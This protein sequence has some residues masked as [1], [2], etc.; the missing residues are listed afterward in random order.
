MIET[1]TRYH[2]ILDADTMIYYFKFSDAVSNHTKYSDTMTQYDA[3]ST[4]V[5]LQETTTA[6]T[7]GVWLL[8]VYIYIYICI[9]A[10]VCVCVCVL[11]N[12]CIHSARVQSKT[13]TFVY[14]FRL[15]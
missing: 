6:D 14:E 3:D 11:F 12:A 10:C 1:G 13:Y 9:Y 15:A 8:L 2:A 4:V 7:E 5:S